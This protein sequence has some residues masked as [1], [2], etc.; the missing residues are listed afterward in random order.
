MGIVTGR[1][2]E[3]VEK[4]DAPDMAAPSLLS[5]KTN[6]QK[7]S[8]TSRS[9]KKDRAKSLENVSKF[10]ILEMLQ[11]DVADLRVKIGK[12][13]VMVFNSSFVGG[14]VI[15]IPSARA[16][17]ITGRLEFIKSASN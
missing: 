15:C 12:D 8:G 14:L 4:I 7:L 10:D 16:N 6:K 9:G 13:G 2:D 3:V 5:T 17:E 11:Q 1:D